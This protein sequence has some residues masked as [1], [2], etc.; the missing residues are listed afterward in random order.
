MHLVLVLD[1]GFEGL[2]VVALT[3]FLLHHDFESVVVVSPVGDP[4]HGLEQVAKQFGVPFRRQIIGAESILQSL[5]LEIR[6]YF[7]CI[8][9]LQQ[10]Q[11]G[12]YLYVD[13]DTLCVS[14]L[15][16]LEDLPLDVSRP[17]A[18]CSHGRPMPDRSLVLGLETQYHYF[19]AGVMLFDSA[20]LLVNEITPAAVVDYYLKHRALCRFREQC[21]LNGLMQGKVQFLPGQYNLLSWMRERQAQGRWHDVAANPMAYCLPDV[22]ERMAIVHL[23]AGALPKQ[24]D[25]SRHERVDCY[26][27]YLE[28]AL[29]QGQPL[30]QLSRFGDW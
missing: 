23:S 1:S 22:R 5:P 25:P 7:F 9:A 4:L 15:S 18:A 19:N 11:P 29:L 12:R 30:T 3:S 16:A 26:W 24:V 10:R 17:L 20:A 28:Q 8:E 21:A 6:P 27:L 2:S 14:D 13:A